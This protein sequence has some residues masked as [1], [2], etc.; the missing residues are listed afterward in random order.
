MGV[1]LAVGGYLALDCFC[2]NWKGATS[3]RRAGQT[4]LISLQQPLK[5]LPWDINEVIHRKAAAHHTNPPPLTTITPPPFYHLNNPLQPPLPLPPCCSATAPWKGSAV[6]GKKPIQLPL[7]AWQLR[8]MALEQEAEVQRAGV[9][10]CACVAMP[11]EGDNSLA[12]CPTST[13]KNVSTGVSTMLWG[14]VVLSPYFS[15]FCLHP[16]VCLSLSERKSLLESS[17]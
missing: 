9:C 5:F 4:G 13:E 12:L 8:S 3:Q 7:R 2:K 16:V 6:P 11:G 14:M 1:G 10:S 17:T 15:Y